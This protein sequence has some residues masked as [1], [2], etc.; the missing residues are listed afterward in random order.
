MSRG[1]DDA[2]QVGGTAMTEEALFHEALAKPPTERDAFLDAACEGNAGLRGEVGSLLALDTPAVARGADSSL[3]SPLPRAP[4]RDIGAVDIPELESV[5][6]GGTRAR[7]GL[8]AD[9]VITVTSR[10]RG[11]IGLSQGA[12]FCA[13]WT[14]GSVPV[15][16]PSGTRSYVTARNAFAPPDKY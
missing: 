4:Q 11:Q 2:R 7:P 9:D 12:V 10:I 5:D 16:A 15:F 14:D 1:H 13:A 6:L 8:F 3:K